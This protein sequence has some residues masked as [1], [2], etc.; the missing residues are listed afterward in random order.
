MSGTHEEDQAR[1]FAVAW[2]RWF[3]IL[4]SSDTRIWTLCIPLMEFRR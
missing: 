2:I 1:L 4:H 3:G